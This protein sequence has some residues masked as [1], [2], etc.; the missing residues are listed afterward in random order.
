M[1][2]RGDFVKSH[3]KL[4]TPWKAHTASVDVLIDRRNATVA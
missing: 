2:E 4:L 3:A 1:V